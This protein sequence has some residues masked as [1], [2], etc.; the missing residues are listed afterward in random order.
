[1]LFLLVLFLF[2]HIKKKIVQF[3]SC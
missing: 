2:K 3:W 1:M